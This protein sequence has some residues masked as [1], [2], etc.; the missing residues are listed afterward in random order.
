M[1]RVLW[2]VMLFLEGRGRGHGLPPVVRDVLLGHCR[3]LVVVLLV[4]MLRRRQRLVRVVLRV[5]PW[6]LLLLL[7]LLLLR[8]L[9]VLHVESVLRTGRRRWRGSAVLMLL[10]RVVL[11]VHGHP[12]DM[13]ARRGPRGR[14]SGRRMGPVYR[15]RDGRRLLDVLWMRVR[16]LMLMLLLLRWRRRVVDGGHLLLVVWRG[17][18]LVFIVVERAFTEKVGRPLVLVRLSILDVR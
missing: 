18:L 2:W 14:L 7:L 17:R 6:Y 3:M 8:L 16:L 15:R 10:L 4:V 13:V 1:L 12:L 9:V 11:R 5:L